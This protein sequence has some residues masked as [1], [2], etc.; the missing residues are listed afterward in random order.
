MNLAEAKALKP[1]QTIY[2][3][4]HKNADGSRQRWKVNG[5]IQVWKTNSKRVRVP[6]KNGLRNFNVMTEASMHCYSLHPVLCA[7]DLIDQLTD[8]DMQV[9]AQ[10]CPPGTE[11]T[12]FGI[13]EV[14]MVSLLNEEDEHAPA[15]D[16]FFLQ[17]AY[18]D[19]D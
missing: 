14:E 11:G 5:A 18:I 4:D 13:T 9:F 12:L 16:V 3:I 19:E 15:K 6:L 10:H 8:R 17:I 7:G 1:G 2:H